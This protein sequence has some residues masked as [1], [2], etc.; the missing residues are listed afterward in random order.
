MD[1]DTYFRILI[2]YVMGSQQKR[3]TMHSS[4]LMNMVLPCTEVDLTD[5]GVSGAVD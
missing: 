3:V 5:V 2:M 1:V 4:A